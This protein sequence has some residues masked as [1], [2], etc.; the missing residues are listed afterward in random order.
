[1]SAIAA[2][3]YLIRDDDTHACRNRE[4]GC[5]IDSTVVG[6]DDVAVDGDWNATGDTTRDYDDDGNTDNCINCNAID[7]DRVDNAVVGDE[8]DGNE[9]A[10]STAAPAT[11]TL[12]IPTAI[13]T[14]ARVIPVWRRQRR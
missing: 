12:S 11:L 2:T 8:D 1:M 7:Y 9:T 13:T 14:T 3:I 5:D 6:D 10:M 4:Y